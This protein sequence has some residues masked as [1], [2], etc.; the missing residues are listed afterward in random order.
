MLFAAV[1]TIEVATGV[2]VTRTATFEPSDLTLAE[3]PG[4]DDLRAEM[5]QEE[6][7]RHEAEAIKGFYLYT[8]PGGQVVRMPDVVR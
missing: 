2:L 1:L 3:L 4:Y 7:A 8:L 5:P 6:A